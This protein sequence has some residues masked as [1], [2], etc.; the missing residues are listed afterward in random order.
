MGD[1]SVVEIPQ[2]AQVVIIGGGIIG[3]SIAFHLTLRGLTDVILV[4]RKQLTSGTTWHAAGLVGQLRATHNLTRLAQYTTELYASLE[5]TTGQATGFRQIG[6]LALATTKE[7]FEEL[8]RGASMARC[9]GLEVDIV[10]PERAREMWPFMTTD[11]VVGAVHLPK[12]G[13]TNPIDTT[14][15]LAKAAK[16]RGARIFEN[17]KVN[18]IIV[19]DGR[20]VCVRT[21]QGDIRA[22]IVVNAAGMWA[23][24]LGA[25]AGTTVPLHAAEHFYIVTEPVPGLPKHLPVLRD[26]DSCAYF[27]EDAGKLLVGWFEPVAKPW[28]TKEIPESFSFDTLPDDLE[29]IEPL[30][31]Q[32]IRRVPAL[33][34]TGIQL[35]FNGPE[36]FTPDDRYLLGETPEV[37]NL[38][39]AAGFNSIGIQSAGGAGKVLADWIIDGHPPMDLWDVDI[40]RMMPFQRNRLYLHDRTVEALGLLYAMHWPFRQPETARGVR[41]ST[42]HDR[43][44]VNGACFGEVA[45]W[46]RP[47][48]YA[49]TGTPAKYEYSYGRQNWFN[50]SADEHRA[51]RSSVGLFDQSSFGKY[52]VEGPDAEVVLNRISANNVAVPVGRIVYTQW[53]NERGGIEADLTV[54]RETENRYLIV[55]AAATQT[56]DLSWL[57][58]NIPSDARAIAVD[59]TSGYAVLGVMG[60]QSRNLLSRLT[61]ADLS[62]AAFPFATSQI[63]DLGYARVR[64]SR[65][66]YVGELG[67][68]LYIPTEFV[69]DIFDRIEAEGR[70]FEMRL[71]G[72]HAL[73][74][75]R[76][77]KAYRH[78]GHD[79]TDEDTPLEAGLGFAVSWEKSAEFIGRAALQKQKSRGVTRR[80]ASFALS[81]P[82]KLLY[83]NEPIW[84][85]G[86]LVGRIT[87]AAYGHTIGKSIGMGYVQSGGE[88][89]DPAFVRSGRYEIEVAGE[90]VP[91]EITLQPF[92][93]PSG[94]RVKDLDSN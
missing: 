49:P 8:K 66:T 3:C 33:G 47:N 24:G 68:E 80:L 76:M 87:S 12:D 53:L 90:R 70:S 35:F 39:V 37:R 73:D 20:A 58:R 14:Q 7:R 51:V 32:A 19:E 27:K 54:T 42:L 63:I 89:V 77:E 93:D 67:W 94:R 30:L 34:S 57:Q 41:R 26:A 45:G 23:H 44:S 82:N 29:H 64:A 36:S 21:A 4:E 71:A 16:S 59:V 2:K 72:Y 40:R 52:I 74:S 1:S 79:I 69:A 85:D 61:N 17:L 11:D 65:I 22:D 55:T 5:S 83:H 28:G 75:L 62:N 48:W 38:F 6:S 91:A 10:T 81:D 15:A 56:R 25:A 43:L 50:Y 78:W 9:F 13:Q 46:E 84:R 86:V 31:E 92:Y 88:I 60:P 18:E